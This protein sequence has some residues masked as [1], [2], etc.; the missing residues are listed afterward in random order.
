KLLRALQEREVVR[1]GSNKPVKTDCRIVVATNRN[2][3]DEVKKGNFREDLYYRLF[4]LPIELPPLRERD[5]DIIL[6]AKFFIASFCKE[7]D[8]SLLTLSTAA[9]KKLMSYSYPGNIRELKAIIEL[10]AVMSNGEE[11][12]Q[13]EISFSTDDPLPDALS[14]NMTLKEYNNRIIEIYLKKHDDNI[15]L[16]AE[17]LD[18]G[19]ST[20]YR[21]LKEKKEG[22]GA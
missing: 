11:I 19:V 9:Q 20:I 17:K 10:A 13:D 7:N 3:R 5:K 1:I 12:D 22:A 18:I 6:L 8:M 2:L 4:G 16:V 14:E 21:M 15:K